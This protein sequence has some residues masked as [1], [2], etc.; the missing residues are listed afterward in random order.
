M[1]AYGFRIVGDCRN[2]RRLIDWQ[3][4]FDAYCQCDDRA[5][6]F[7]ESYLSAFTFGAAFRQHLERTG[8]TKGYNAECGAFWLWFDI[9]REHDLDAATNDARRLCAVLCERFKLDG[10]ELLI[11][12]SGSK[13]F[14]VG[15]PVSL[16]E[17]ELS[18]M[19]NEVGRRFAETIAERAGVVIDCGVY[20]KVRAFRSPNSRHA[21]TGLHK[22]RLTFDELLNLTTAA[23]KT[24]AA[25][26]LPFDI[27][28]AP[29][30]N[31]QAVT[32]WRLAAEQVG[33]RTEANKQ[34]RLALNGSA[35]LNR[36]TLDF[37]RDGATAGDRHRLLF[38]AAANLAELGC[39]FDLAWALLSEPA[40][41]SG[42]APAETKR[43]IECGLTHTH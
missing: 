11:F 35:T 6:V 36:S 21:K 26:P 9:D 33:N 13:G 40:L 8:S 1:S 28:T 16:W 15:L 14:H 22:R 38:S 37:I 42:L 2:E 29:P 31:S 12:Y 20:D 18:A 17:P 5:D 43:Q 10:D 3:A 7:T 19:F 34:R 30:L 25:E 24:L 23:I 32:D 39:S 41:D 4:A 27:P